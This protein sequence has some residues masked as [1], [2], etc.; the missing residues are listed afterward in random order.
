[1]DE[2]LYLSYLRCLVV[3]VIL[4]WSRYPLVRLEFHSCY[5][6]L[7]GLGLFVIITVSACTAMPNN[8]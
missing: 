4:E 3:R 1:M 5:A 6:C 8:N 2:K 7:H